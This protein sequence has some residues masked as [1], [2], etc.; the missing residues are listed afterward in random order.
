MPSRPYWKG[1]MRLSLVTFAVALYPVIATS[2]RIAFHQLQK[3]TACRIREKKVC[4]DSGVE[5]SADDIVKGYEYEKG[6]YV[7]VEDEDLDKIRLD[8][9]KTI[10]LTQFFKAA[11]VDPIYYDKPYYVVPDGA[12]AEEAYSVVREALARS[13][14]AALGRVVLSGRERLTAIMPRDKGFV[15]HTLHADDLVRK[16]ATY[17]ADIRADIG[18]EMADE[19]AVAAQLIARRTAAFDPRKFIDRYEEALRAVIDEKLKGR[20]PSV[21]ETVPSAANVVNLMEAL[22]RSLGEQPI[23]TPATASGADRRTRA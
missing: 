5:V 13:G 16:P 20:E 3:G 7:V 18:P 19:V 21:V 10:E 17:F 8:T 6:R 11:E 15:L 14:Q 9:K 1:H 2:S 23:D 22:K 4:G 12:M